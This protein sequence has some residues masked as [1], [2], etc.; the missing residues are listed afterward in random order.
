MKEQTKIRMEMITARYARRLAEAGNAGELVAAR[1]A[2]FLRGFERVRADVVR[3]AME[4][5]GAELVR[6]GHAFRVD[7]GDTPEQMSIELH[8]IITGAP[9]SSAKVIRLFSLKGTEGR[10]EVV[11][12]VEMERNPMELTRFLQI[13][14]ITTEVVE[15]MLVDAI[16]QVFACN[17]G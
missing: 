14:E 17:G 10:P 3:P 12:E 15:Q 1:K 6:A 11:A 16:E 5:I 8:L 7:L 2:E 9:R 13:D 4:G